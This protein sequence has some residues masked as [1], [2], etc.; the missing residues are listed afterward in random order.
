MADELTSKIIGLLAEYIDSHN[1]DCTLEE[2]GDDVR[3]ATEEALKAL[4]EI[5]Q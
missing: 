2:F 3:I 1:P 4:D 5:F